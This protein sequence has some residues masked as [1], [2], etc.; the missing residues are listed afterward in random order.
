VARH[1][2]LEFRVRI[3]RIDRLA[4]GGR[5]LLDYKTG[6]ALPDWRG[7]RPDNPQLPIYALL[8]PQGLVA[9]AYARVNASDCGFVAESERPGV[10]KRG[11]RA[12]HLEGRVSFAALLDTWAQRIE[13][14]ALEFR[15]GH[16]RVAPTLRA[17]A[18]CRL[19]PLC[20]VPSALGAQADLDG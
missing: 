20:R 5:V 13:R 9:V 1:G 18:S 8:R 6:M 15:D 4:D 2:G 12:T 19:Q 10:F 7:D 11:G 16:A 3:D 14:I 17:C